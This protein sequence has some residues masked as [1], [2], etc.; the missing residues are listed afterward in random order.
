MGPNRT[1]RWDG[2]CVYWESRAQSAF[3]ACGA[4]N[5]GWREGGSD[6]GFFIGHE[7]IWSSRVLTISSCC[8]VALDPGMYVF[9]LNPGVSLNFVPPLIDIAPLNST[10]VYTPKTHPTIHIDEAPP[11]QTIFEPRDVDAF[12]LRR[13]GL[14]TVERQR[15]RMRQGWVPII[16][17]FGSAFAG[18]YWANE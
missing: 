8:L 12:R 14:G 18:G 4:Q 15:N 11:W 5:E 7:S 1:F 3:E 10:T 6:G 13:I 17:I 9:Q 2:V 16:F